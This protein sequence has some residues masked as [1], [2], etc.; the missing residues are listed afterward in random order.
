MYTDTVA[1]P[2][3]PA[4]ADGRVIRPSAEFKR[5]ALGVLWAIFFFFIV[6]LA[7]VAGAIVLATRYWSR[8]PRATV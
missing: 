1:Y 7:L 2:P 3:A 6:Y 8:G 5:E 4:N